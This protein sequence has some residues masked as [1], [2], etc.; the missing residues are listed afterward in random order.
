MTIIIAGYITL[1]GLILGSFYNVVALRVP[2][3]SRCCGRRR[4]V[5]AVGQVLLHET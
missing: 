1:I 2:A 4:I 5:Q 3:G